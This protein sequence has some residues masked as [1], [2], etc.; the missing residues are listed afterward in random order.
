MRLPRAIQKWALIGLVICVPIC[1]HFIAVGRWL[2]LN[3]PEGKFST[4]SGY[5]ASQRPPERVAKLRTSKGVCYVAYGS[6]IGSKLAI[7]SGPPAYVFDDSGN[8]VYYSKAIGDDSSF[9]EK[10]PPASQQDMS[11]DEIKAINFRL[12]AP[13]NAAPPH[14]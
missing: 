13:P 11:P 9:H 7:P 10:W 3:S 2:S 12:E 5:L 14:R 4:L 8:L 6:M 1:V